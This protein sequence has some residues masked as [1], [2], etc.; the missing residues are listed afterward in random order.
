MDMHENKVYNINN[1]DREFNIHSLNVDETVKAAEDNRVD[2]DD[3][4]DE[5]DPVLAAAKS[6]EMFSI[7]SEFKLPKN[8]SNIDFKM[9]LNLVGN[10]KEIYNQGASN[11]FHALSLNFSSFNLG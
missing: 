4:M 6:K 5:Y 10:M 7:L 3:Y 11:F 2:Y 9:G 1:L 8:Q